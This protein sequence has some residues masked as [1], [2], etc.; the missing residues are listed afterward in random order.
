M[1]N[2]RR[3]YYVR[4]RNHAMSIHSRQE[5]SSLENELSSRYARLTQLQAQQDMIQYTTAQLADAASPEEAEELQ[6][7]L[8]RQRNGLAAL[9]SAQ[10]EPSA[11]PAEKKPGPIARIRGIL[12]PK[13]RG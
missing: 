8:A 12:T 5:Q 11:P 10:P 1:K 4:R 3:Y 13:G 2:L 6:Q 9:Q 7:V